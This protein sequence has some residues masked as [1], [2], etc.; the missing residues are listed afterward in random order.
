MKPRLLDLFCGAGGCTK[1]YQRAGFSVIGVDI[2]PQPHYCGDGFIQAD[3]LALMM[4]CTPAS[5]RQS[6]TAIHASPPCQAYSWSAKRW[7][8][9]REDLVAPTRNALQRIGLPFVIENVVGAP[10]LDPMLLCGQMFGLGVIRHRLF[11]CHGFYPLVPNHY[12]CNGLVK[13]GKAST[14]AGHGGETRKGRGSLAQKQADMG[15]DWMTLAE[16]N[17]AIPPAYTH[18]I[19]RQLL[20]ALEQ[21]A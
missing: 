5:L 3:A 11:E 4:A 13:A 12:G 16:L 2:N 6:F 10:L 15:I 1:G 20:A 19:G 17:Q 9:P 14:V 21:V 7:D 18:F 8:R